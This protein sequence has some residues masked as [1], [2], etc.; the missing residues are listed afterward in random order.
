MCDFIFFILHKKRLYAKIFKVFFSD[1]NILFFP[2]AFY[3]YIYVIKMYHFYN[4]SIIILKESAEPEENTL[5]KYNKK[6]SI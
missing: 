6:R 2:C 1:H 5:I 4:T 3:I